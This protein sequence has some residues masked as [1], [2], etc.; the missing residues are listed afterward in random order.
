MCYAKNG[1]VIG[2][3]AGQQSRIHCT[4]L[5]GDKADN[6]WFR[7]HPKIFE[8]KWKKG[9]KRPDK[10]NAIDLFVSGQIPDKDANGGME[11]ELYES[12]F[13]EVPQELTAEER[14]E[15]RKQLTDV[16]VSSDA[17]V[18]S[19]IFY[20]PVIRERSGANACSS[21]RSSTMF[22]VPLRLVRSILP[23]LVDRLM[24]RPSMMRR[25]SAG[26]YLLSRRLGSSTIK[27][28]GIYALDCLGL[29][30]FHRYNKSSFL[31]TRNF[32]RPIVWLP[33]IRLNQTSSMW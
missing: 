25:R 14:K 31:A 29:F 13:E 12:V 33:W 4:R 11:R 5:A 18:S 9:T 2:L 32:V 6:W 22:S 23:P 28:L 27:C 24:I 1:Q 21:S 17:F 19:P 3:G 20:A 7:Q 10:S 15:W 30:G 8:F 16:A 26:L